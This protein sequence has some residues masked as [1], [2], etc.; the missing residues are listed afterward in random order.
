MENLY[1]RTLSGLGWSGAAQVVQQ[2]FQ[3]IVYVILARL[4]NPEK[5]G[6][7][8]MIIVFT[9]FAGLFRELGFGVSIIQTV[10]SAGY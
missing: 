3:F 4:L 7:I 10:L 8:G 9:G 5:F 6:L 2:L 1:G